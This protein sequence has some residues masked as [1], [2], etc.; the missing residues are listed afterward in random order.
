MLKTFNYNK[1][2]FK[3][4]SYH[5]TCTSNKNF[6]KNELC[7]FKFPHD[8]N[9]VRKQTLLPEFHSLANDYL[10]RF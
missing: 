2:H 9:K 7:T 10:H 8:T 4:H 6:I 5:C 1:T 3:E